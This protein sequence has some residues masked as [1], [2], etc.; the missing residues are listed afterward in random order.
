MG[1]QIGYATNYEIIKG[2]VGTHDGIRGSYEFHYDRKADGIATLFD[3]G[4]AAGVRGGGRGG[5]GLGE[6]PLH[7]GRRRTG[8]GQ[9]PESVLSILH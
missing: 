8:T 1:R 3:E 9:T 5:P 2:K 6:R 7:P 4:V